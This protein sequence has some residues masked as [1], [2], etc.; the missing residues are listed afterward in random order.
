[1]KITGKKAPYYAKLWIN[2]RRSTEHTEFFNWCYERGLR[3]VRARNNYGLWII[4]LPTD[5]Q[6]VEF[7]LRWG[8]N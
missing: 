8:D 4:T 6:A 7:K 1:M 2:W 5:T 3:V